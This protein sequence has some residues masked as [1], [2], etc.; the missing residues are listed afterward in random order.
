M[1]VAIQVA[2]SFMAVLSFGLV[3]EMPRKYLGWSG[4]T[5]GVCWLVY[6]VVKAGT[7]SMI[8]GAFLSSLSVALMG[9][10]FARIFRAPVSV[11]LVPGILPL[12]PGTSIYNSVYYV[13]RNSREESMYYLVETLQIAGAIA[14]AVF[15]MDS[16]FKLVGIRLCSST[17]SWVSALT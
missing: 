6:L 7:G 8:L 1:V 2:G 5:G 12:V 3:L 17:L 15:L 14:L 10:L 4:L 9:H 13:I 16:V 11:F